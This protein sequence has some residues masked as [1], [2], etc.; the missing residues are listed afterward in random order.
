LLFET[1]LID[2]TD[3]IAVVTLN[4]P[5]KLNA[6][7]LKMRSEIL[8]LLEE[9]RE[10]DDVKVVI[11]TG[12]G[13]A[14]SAGADISEFKEGKDKLRASQMP[15]KDI[16]RHIYEFEKPVIGAINGVAT[17][18][19]SQ[20]TLAFDMNIASED[21]K[22][23][24]GATLLGLLCPYGIIRLPKE[25]TRFRA[26]ELMMT[27]RF[28][29]AREACEWGIVNKVVP[30]DK[31]MEAAME[32]AAKIKEMP[33]LSI[34]AIKE[35][36]NIGMGGYEYSRQVFANLQRTEDADEGARAFLEKRKPHFTG[37]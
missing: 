7:S 29:S 4:R 21:A 31:L 27:C 3:G 34:R 19:G 2:K 20:F 9:L 11:F 30:K 32:L 25:I 26:K 18:K 1:L 5:E 12:A 33:P 13:S 24:W 22:F 37:R 36:V 10:D 15:D 16:T 17:G 35:A 6:V 28:L 23:G 14:F 8:S